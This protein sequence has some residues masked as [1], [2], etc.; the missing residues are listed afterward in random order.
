MLALSLLLVWTQLA[1]GLHAL[2]HVREALGHTP[3]HSLTVPG[4]E[5]CAMC[6]LF[7][8]GA[9]AAAGDMEHTCEL[10]ASDEA[11]QLA[12]VAFAPAAPAYYQSRAPPLF[13]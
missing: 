6:A 3:D 5:V 4:D 1:A 9:S 7:A 12:S 11:L 2:E 10:P 13:L 8:G